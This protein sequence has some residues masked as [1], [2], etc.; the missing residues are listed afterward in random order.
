MPDLR[1]LADIGAEVES[2]HHFRG[3]IYSVGMISDTVKCPTCGAP[4]ETA[5][6]AGRTTW[7]LCSKGKAE[8]QQ[9]T[10]GT[11]PPVH[12]HTSTHTVEAQAA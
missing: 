3:G 10:W 12:T 1:E 2:A 7:W 6:Q 5:H 9:E 4:A 11:T 8:C